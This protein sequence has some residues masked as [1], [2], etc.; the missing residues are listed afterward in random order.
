MD[1]NL[2]LNI[3]RM[4][5]AGRLQTLG[6]GVDHDDYEEM[7]GMTIFNFYT[8]GNYDPTKATLQTYIGRIAR[9]VVTDYGRAYKKRRDRYC[10]IDATDV[11]D[12]LID[13]WDTDTPMLIEE[14]EQLIDEAVSKLTDRQQKLFDLLMEEHSNKE[15]AGL[16]GT[17]ASNIATEACKMKQRMKALLQ[18]AA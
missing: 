3:A 6:R 2:I 16:M 14:Q 5:V 11:E 4:A 13:V 10:D 18:D 1:G 17:K 8:K 9:N 12:T 15:I 7:V